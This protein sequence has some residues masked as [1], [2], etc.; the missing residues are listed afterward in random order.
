MG[1][2]VAGNKPPPAS[3]GV[4]GSARPVVQACPPLLGVGGRAS[5]PEGTCSPCR[6]KETSP[7]ALPWRWHQDPPSPAPLPPPG[8]AGRW[9][10]ALKVAFLGLHHPGLAPPAPR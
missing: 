2:R 8:Q 6:R 9:L 3:A 7:H 4:P 5:L 10:E 1:A